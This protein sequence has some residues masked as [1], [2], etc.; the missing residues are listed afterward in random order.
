MLLLRAELGIEHPKILPLVPWCVHM[1]H[2]FE[3]IS[4]RTPLCLRSTL[5]P[6]QVCYD[7]DKAFKE[8]AI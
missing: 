8:E 7:D 3:A 6:K 2:I 1:G 5:L 4:T